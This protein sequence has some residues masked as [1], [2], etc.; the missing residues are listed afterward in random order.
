MYLTI[1]CGL[2]KMPIG[3]F[4]KLSLIDYLYYPVSIIYT[5]GCNYR[6]GYCHNSELFP[7]DKGENYTIDQIMNLLDKNI[8]WIEG[9]CITGGEPT[10]APE[11]EQLLR[12]IR[13]KNILIKLDTNGSNPDIVQNLINEQ[14]IDYVALDIKTKLDDE[15]YSKVVGKRMSVK[16]IEKTLQILKTS[17]LDFEI[18]TTVIPTIIGEKEIL[19]IADSTK[20]VPVYYLQ[21]FKPDFTYKPEFR[22]IKPYPDTFL[23]NIVEKVKKETDV[24]CKLR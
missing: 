7:I 9:V 6:C 22:K 19:E 23:T 20:T 15:S 4:K 17:S 1:I 18:R 10:L 8:K 11:L 12:R 14:L 16:T 24:N 3:G 5:K 13:D 21:Q 2:N